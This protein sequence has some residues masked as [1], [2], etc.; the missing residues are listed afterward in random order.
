MYCRGYSL[1]FCLSARGIRIIVPIAQG[2]KKNDGGYDG[3]GKGK[4]D[5]V[6]YVHGGRPVNFCG[7]EREMG[8]VLK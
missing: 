1:L 6:E 3:L 4:H 5:P 2:G 7:F 8:I